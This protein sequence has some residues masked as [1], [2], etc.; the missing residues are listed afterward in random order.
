MREREVESGKKMH[1]RVAGAMAAG[2]V[3]LLQTPAHAD[4]GVVSH[5]AGEQIAQSN[6]ARSFAIPAQPL[7][8]ALDRFADQ[9]G[10]SFAYRTG[11]L[12][13]MRSRGVSGMLKPREALQQLLAGTGVSFAFT[14]ANTV[15]IT[16]APETGAGA[17]QLDPV[18][19]QGF[20]VPQQ[21]M[22][23]NLP[24]PY[25][26]GQVATGSQLG[27]LGNRDV[28]D[29]PFNQTSYTAK[30]A[31][32]QQAKTMRDVL[33]DDPS[34]RA[35]FP[36][37]SVAAD[38]VYIRGFSLASFAT[39]Y[40]GLYGMLPAFSIMPELAERIEVLKGPS[41]MLNGMA[42][43]G[44]IGGTIN[45]V[46]KRAPDEGLTQITANY[47]SASQF[48]G[49]ADLARR[50]GTDKQFGMRLNVAFRS[51]LTG[52][53]W[54]TD[55]RAL[56]T[57]GLDFRGE[58]VRLA[59]DAG[60]QYQRTGGLTPYLGVNPGIPLPWA[61]NVRNNTGAQP[62]SYRAITDVF[63]VVRGEFDVTDR[64]TAYAAFGSHDVRYRDYGGGYALVVSNLNGNSTATP[65]TFHSYSTYLTGQAGVR[66]LVD[67]GP[68]GH[69]L[70]LSATTYTRENG[71][72]SV[73]GKAYATNLYNP[74]VI[75]PPSLADPAANKASATTMSS[76]ALA[77]TLTA[78]DKRIQLTVGARLQQVQTVNFNTTSGAQTSESDKSALS[79]SV[80]LIIK[81]WQ[82]VSLYG[83]FIQGLQPGTI[84]GNTFTNAGEA[85]PPY[86]TTQYEAGVKVD[87]G[88]FTTTASMFQISQPSILTNTANNTQFLG[89]EQVNQGLE[90]N[91]FGEPVEGIRLLG[92]LML[93]NA[94]LA[95][96]QGGL[97]DGWT[98]PFS[99]DLNLN[100]GGEWDLPFARGVTLN[101]RAIYTSS[102]YIDTTYPR[103]SL[104]AW[105][106]FDVGVRYTFDT[107]RSPTGKP[108]ALRFNVDNLLD[109]N[110]WAGGQSA[111]LLFLGAP[112]TF[113]LAMTADF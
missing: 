49:H 99:P 87:W 6:Q 44:G 31:Q 77:D 92:G 50:V 48:G 20:A 74:T 34:V 96:T 33:I 43:D 60:V 42:P 21:A 79:P 65:L 4:N 2:A 106:R 104:P 46:P 70:G 47:A 25:A 76:L 108:V 54:N 11:D 18:Q 55:Q 14:G 1:W 73:A 100:L 112:R 107:D 17:L 90:L 3:L 22:I 64:V 59:V 16:R 102:Q 39:S 88:K 51:G 23:D 13:A 24:P 12:S 63:G 78:A 67:T 91:V 111:T 85:F 93:L 89:G 84:V 41:A 5:A 53:Q 105:T 32:D 58:R 80:A 75:A 69:E 7:A 35:S 30:K 98:A 95:K 57:L 29:T 94:V 62:W 8:S 45:V 103:R 26:G 9:T 40:G 101:G 113:R 28:M 56:S 86:K 83:N 52:V 72:G 10:I 81:P 97:R 82:N 66:A 61:P 38:N 71:F 109:T 110:Y 19:V 68:I 36:D 27:L 15:T 37:G